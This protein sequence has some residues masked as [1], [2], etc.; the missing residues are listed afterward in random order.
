MDTDQTS[1]AEEPQA[2][3]DSTAPAEQA[4]QSQLFPADY[5]AELRAESA[6]HRNRSKSLATELVHAW[7][8]VD[9]RL[10]DPTDLH[11]SD[12]EADDDGNFSRAAVT[13][14][15]DRLL[16]SKPHLGAARPAPLPQGARPEAEQVSLLRLLNARP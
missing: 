15:I 12:V 5:V 1:P 4:E 11:A 8:A 10:V 3:D 7:A 13:A 2:V 14:A 6:K 16:K 9:G